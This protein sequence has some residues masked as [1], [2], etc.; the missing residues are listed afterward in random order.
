M[1]KPVRESPE[2]KR[3]IRPA[4]A[5]SGAAPR[6]AQPAMR[7]SSIDLTMNT[8]NGPKL[9]DVYGALDTLPSLDVNASTSTE[10]HSMQATGPDDQD[11]DV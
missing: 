3:A 7:H 9:L 6:T 4:M 5:T 10:R 1:G 11:G 8:C 2:S